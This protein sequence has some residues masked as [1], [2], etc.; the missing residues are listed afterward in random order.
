ML[1]IKDANNEKAV[2]FGP[3]TEHI[4][5]ISVIVSYTVIKEQIHLLEKYYFGLLRNTHLW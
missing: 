4:T 1:K 5:G 2:G 3:I